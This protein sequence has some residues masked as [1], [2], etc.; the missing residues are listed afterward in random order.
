MLVVFVNTIYDVR[1]ILLN[2]IPARSKRQTGA[3]RLE[4]LRSVALE[5][6]K[7]LAKVDV[8][9]T[10]D[11]GTVQDFSDMTATDKKKAIKKVISNNLD[12]KLKE[13]LKQLE[14][15]EFRKFLSTISRI[16]KMKT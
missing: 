16:A 11:E 1:Y 4:Q 10:A 12:L 6:L 7:K 8:E 3:E 5:N 2:Y 14:V 9:L 13:Y 15:F